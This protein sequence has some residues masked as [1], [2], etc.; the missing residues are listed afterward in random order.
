LA[1]E[2]LEEDG[3]RRQGR[4]WKPPGKRERRASLRKS[5]RHVVDEAERDGGEASA[6]NRLRERKKRRGMKNRLG[7]VVRGTI[8]GRGI[9]LRHNRPSPRSELYTSL[10]NVTFH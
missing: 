4:T 3:M 5:G 2:K 8:S 9:S 10:F 1:L 7:A 6:V